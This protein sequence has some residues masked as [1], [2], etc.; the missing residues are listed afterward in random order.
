M[1]PKN[2]TIIGGGACGISLFIELFLQLRIAD[3]HQDISIT[4]V[5][6]NEQVGRGLA[7]GTK[8]PGHILNTQAQL[9]GIH[10]TEP[11]HF[12]QWLRQHNAQVNDEVVDNQGQ[13]EAF[14]TRRLYGEYLQEQFEH[15]FDLAQKEG[16]QLELIQASARKVSQNENGY[17]VSLSNDTEISCEYLVLCLGTPVSNLYSE[18]GIHENYFDSPWPSSKIL[19]NVPKDEAVAIIGSSLSA[20]DALMTLADNEHEGKITFYSLDGLLP[21]VQVEKPEPYEREYLTISSLHQIQRTELRSPFVS[22]VFRLFI[23]EAEHLSG[24]KIDWEEASRK[25]KSA[26]E[27]LKQDIE[28]AAQGGD[29][30]MNIPYALRYDSS[31]MWNLLDEPARLKFKKWLGNYWA[32]NRHCMPM[33]N[34]QRIE[35]LFASGQLEVVAELEDIVYDDAQQ[36]FVLSCKEKSGSAKYLINATGPASA[37]KD[38]NSELVQNLAESGLIEPEKTGGI[39]INTQ[40]MQVIHKEKSLQNLYALGHLANGLLLDSNAVWFNVKTIGTLSHHLIHNL[41]GENTL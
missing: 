28:I 10:F 4:I 38:M 35:K 12:S 8:Q 16:M 2:V 22:E 29:A 17:K 31:Q 39:K 20:I 6:E 36:K 26:H 19:E 27:Y 1:K 25:G 37:V 34:A 21:R 13:D 40:T 41:T 11:E 14:T 33:V 15:Y 5:E 9:M 3:R 7:F 30:L 23:K 18:L 32:I 24:K